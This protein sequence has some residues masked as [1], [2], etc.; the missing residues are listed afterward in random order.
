MLDL[1]VGKNASDCRG[2]SRRD[3]LRVGG[4]SALGL[5]L[6]NYFELQAKAHGQQSVGTRSNINCIL[7]WMQGG[8]SHIDTFDPKPDASAEI[9]GEFTTIPTRIPGCRIVEHFPLLSQQ[10]DKLSLIRGHDP[11]NGSH[12][13]ADH[14]MMTGHRFNPALPFPCFGSVVAK[15]RGYRDGMFPFVQLGRNIDRRFNGGVGGFLGDQ[16]SPFEVHDDPSARPSACDLSIADEATAPTRTTL[17]CHGS[18]SLPTR[19]G[20]GTIGAA[21]AFYERA[22]ALIRFAA[23]EDA[24]DLAKETERVRDQYSRNSFAASRVLARR[25]IEWACISSSP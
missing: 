20:S 11:Q 2:Y 13:V 19:D 16:Y 14:I 25:L 5:T 8:P 18:R 23:S 24:F 22:H 17:R 1:N 15:E 12:G 21:R 4:L 3:F 9:R 6:A 10:F 7:M